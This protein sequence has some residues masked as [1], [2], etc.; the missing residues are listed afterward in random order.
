MEILSLWWPSAPPTWCKKNGEKE[1]SLE[2]S[3]CGKSKPYFMILFCLFFC[4]LFLALL[5]SAPA[6]LFN[7][8]SIS[9]LFQTVVISWFWV[10][11]PWMVWNIAWF[12]CLYFGFAC[13]WKSQIS[14]LWWKFAWQSVAE[15]LFCSPWSSGM[16][17]SEPGSS[18]LGRVW[19]C[20][21]SIVSF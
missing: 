16:K 10:Y 15:W 14:L 9:W 5:H 4:A 18:I 7:L 8:P 3:C 1:M 2:W 19:T 6:L 17:R 20:S 12:I 21:W 13:P 11:D